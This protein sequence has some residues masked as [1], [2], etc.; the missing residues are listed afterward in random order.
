MELYLTPHVNEAA[1]LA[2]VIPSPRPQADVKLFMRRSD[3]NNNNN[4]HNNN[5]NNNKKKSSVKVTRSFVDTKK[6]QSQVSETFFSPQKIFKTFFSLIVLN[7][8]IKEKGFLSQ[9]R[10]LEPKNLTWDRN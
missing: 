6:S 5:N 1:V 7:G 3:N 4:S 9:K 2:V 8:S 10:E